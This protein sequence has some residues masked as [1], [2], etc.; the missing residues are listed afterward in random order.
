MSTGEQLDIHP[1][2]FLLL[3]LG[4]VLLLLPLLGC[5]PVLAGLRTDPRL[6]AVGSLG[7]SLCHELRPLP[8]GLSY[9]APAQAHQTLEVLILIFC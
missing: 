9:P 5:R 2:L 7:N 4:G 8:A 6:S 3:R 1:L